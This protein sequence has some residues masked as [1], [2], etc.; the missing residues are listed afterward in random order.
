M[1]KY[2]VKKGDTLYKIAS[3]YSTTVSEIQKA[4]PSIIKNP[5]LINVGWVLNI[6][7]K[8]S[9]QVA[10]TSKPSEQVAKDYSKIGKQVEQVLKDIEN[11]ESFKELEKML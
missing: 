9:E 4:N 1:L 6:P 10:N 11:L 7:S 3:K 5:N 8:A 2:T